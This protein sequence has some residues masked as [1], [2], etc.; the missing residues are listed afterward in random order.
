MRDGA[1]ACRTSAPF[2][3]AA[4]R[5]FAQVKGFTPA[6]LPLVAAAATGVQ[7]GAAI[8]ATRFAV[9]EVGPFS[10]A[11]LRYGLAVLCL[12]PAIAAMGPFPRV[13]LRDLV[14]IS[15]LGIGQFGVLIAL[16][17]VGLAR[18][19][20]S[21]GAVLFA[22]LPLFTLVMG[23][24]LG[25]ETFSLKKLGGVL[26]TL[27]AVCIALEA[28][29]GSGNVDIVG[30]LAVVAAAFCGAFCSVLYRPFLQRYPVLPVSALAMLASVAALSVP[31][32]ATEGLML[33]LPSFSF[34]AWV[35]IAF[36][37][38]SSGVGYV[39]WLWALSRAP[40]TQVT[41]FLSLSP[42]TA[43]LLGGALLGE[44]VSLAMA[45]GLVCLAAGIC[46]TSR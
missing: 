1:S 8:V 29:S 14:P 25:R 18:V 30:R 32:L 42:V 23:A 41:V 38:V 20:A 31:A 17:N 4:N 27:L 35:A 21:E 16:L 39:L 7:V 15:M 6:R 36:I 37:G 5:V 28:G 19:P 46:L 26:L 34:G 3:S 33:Q 40:P 13:P 22:L 44:T 9:G 43:A 2:A 12:L 45:P 10:I 11:F 24:L